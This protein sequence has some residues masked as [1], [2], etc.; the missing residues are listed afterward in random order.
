MGPGLQLAV[1]A[2]QLG[3]EG[4]GI[5]DRIIGGIRLDEAP[6]EK[7]LGAIDQPCLDTLPDQPLEER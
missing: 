3:F 4:L 1:L 7:N 2:V 5:H 6:V